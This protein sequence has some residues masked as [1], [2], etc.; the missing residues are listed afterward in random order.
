ML[1]G[2]PNTLVGAKAVDVGA[3][4]R[5]PA[6]A[7]VEGTPTEPT[8]LLTTTPGATPKAFVVLKAL[9]NRPPVLEAEVDEPSET[10]LVT[11]VVVV[12][13]DREVKGRPPAV[14]EAFVEAGVILRKNG[15]AVL[16]AV[17]ADADPADKLSGL[18]ATV[19]LEEVVVL[20]LVPPRKRSTTPV[21]VNAGVVV[22]APKMVPA[23][24]NVLAAVVD[25]TMLD[26]LPSDKACAKTPTAL[27]DTGKPDGVIMAG[28]L[29]S[30]FSVGVPL[31]GRET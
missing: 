27:V 13:G 22:G 14:A 11:A 12:G 7:V 9:L 30:L 31:E 20:D 24:G 5:F 17:K 29:V 3:A 25:D 1:L 23:P 6:E 26:L 16:V 8:P 28:V 4:N 15:L 2:D 10:G 19:V 21:G 18:L